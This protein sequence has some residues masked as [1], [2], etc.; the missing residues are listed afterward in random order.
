[1]STMLSKNLIRYTAVLSSVAAFGAM[2]M[3]A[4][5]TNEWCKAAIDYS[6]TDK[7][8]SVL[9]LRAG[10]PVCASSNVT[11]PHELYSGTKSTVG[12]IAAVAVKDQLLR[13]DELASDTLPE[14]RGDPEK[15]KITLR[16]L[17]SMTSGHAQKVG[18]AIGYEE[19]V[20]GP[21]SFSPGTRFQYGPAPLQIFGE[22]MR[23]KLVAAGQNGSPRDYMERRLFSPLG[24][25]VASWRDGPDGNPLMPD[26][27][28]LAAT[29]WAKIGELVRL[30]GRHGG[31]LLVDPQAFKE[32]FKGSVANPAY[33]LTW[34]LPHASTASGPT[35]DGTDISS[36][37]A[38]L[39]SDMVVAGGAGGQR[40]YV[41]PSLKLTIVRQANFD[42][43]AARMRKTP[44]S[45]S[46]THFI[47]LI[48]SKNGVH[49]L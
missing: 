27:L 37:A 42:V 18:R 49:R 13:L 2:A 35:A 33:G 48:I 38:E 46:D 29:E 12:L 14:W 41:I 45:W 21:L 19:A 34:W 28:S 47:H 36:R 6:N 32:L 8:V 7:G 3:A 40:L 20:N 44:S 23:R 24:V 25:R 4:V 16:Q 22:I 11:T 43:T 1:M 30:R 10:R 9:V 26:G 31:K 15:S 17:L 39:P 5:P